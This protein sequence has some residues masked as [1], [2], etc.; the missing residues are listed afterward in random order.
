MTDRSLN[1]IHDCPHCGKPCHVVDGRYPKH[2][3]TGGKDH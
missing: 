2:D 1:G 3:C